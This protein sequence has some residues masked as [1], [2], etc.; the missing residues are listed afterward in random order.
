MSI[1][2]KLSF[3]YGILNMFKDE[4]FCQTLLPEATQAGK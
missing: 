2:V 1:K 3:S 4:M